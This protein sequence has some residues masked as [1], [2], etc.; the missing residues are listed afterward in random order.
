MI[1]KFREYQSNQ[2]DFNAI[3][4]INESHQYSNQI[5]SVMDKL[6]FYVKRSA[7][8]ENSN[9]NESAKRAYG[10]DIRLSHDERIAAACIFN[11]MLVQFKQN[12][13][14]ELSI[15]E[16]VINQGSLLE[17]GVEY[18]WDS[19]AELIKIDEGLKDKFKSLLKKGEDKVNTIAQ[20]VIDGAKDLTAKGVEVV[21]AKK[22][23]L[24]TWAKD[25]KQEFQDRYE[26]LK[27]LVNDIVKKGIDS[28][29]KFIDKLLKV[30]TSI[31]SNLLEVIKK[32]GGTKMEKEEKA[33]EL[34]DIDTEELYKKIEDPGERSFFNNI[35]LRV[36]A[37]LTK[38]NEN[39]AKLMTEAYVAES[40]VDN[41]FIAWLSGYKSDGTKMSW[42]K[43]ILI[44]LCASIIVWLLPK[45]LVFTGLG[46]ALAAFIAGLV[47]LVWNTIGLLK[48]IYKRNK[49]RKQGEKFFDIKTGIFFCASV[50]SLGFSISTFLKTIGPLMREICN[51]MG[52]T[53]GDDMSKF[54]ELF[55]KFTRKISP[56]ECFKEG[57]VINEI[58][59]LN[60]QGADVRDT[61][62]IKSGDEAV[63][64]LD[65]MEGTTDEQV[66]AFK[67]MLKAAQDAKGTSGVYKALEQFAD[68]KD[69]PWTAVFDSQTYGGPKYIRMAIEELS[70]DMGDGALLGNLGSVS[71]HAATG[72]L[73]G[74]ACFL[75]G[76][77][78]DTCVKILQRASELAGKEFVLQ[79][80]EYG[81]GVI[82]QVR[83][84]TTTV[85][86]AFDA[87]GPNIP[88]LPMVMPFFDKKKWGQYKI[89]FASG[90][91][92]SAGY[93]V[94]KV[95][96]MKGDDIKPER[97]CKALDSLKKLH[98]KAWAD[99]QALPKEEG[100]VSEKKQEEK[101]DKVEEPQYIVFFVKPNEST[102]KTVDARNKKEEKKDSAF[103]IVIDTLTM[104][105]ADIC[106]FE[107]SMKIRRR[108]K[109]YY[110]K[111]LFSRL[112]FRPLENN[113]NDTKD[114]I[115]KTL[116]QTM[117]TLITQNVMFG[118]GKKYI[119]SK[120]DGDKEAEFKQRTTTLDTNKSINWDKEKFELGNFK[121]QELFDCVT[122]S[123]SNNKRAYGFL[124]GEYGSKVTIREGKD[125]TLKVSAIRDTSTIENVRYYR[126]SKDDYE[127]AMKKYK[128]TAKTYVD[129]KGKSK[130]GSDMK[131]PKKPTFIKGNDGEYYKRASAKIIKDGTTKTFDF[132]DIKIIPLLKK[133]DL[134]DEII[135]NKKFK[136]LLFKEENG[137]NPELNSAAI[138]ILKPF[139]YRPESS[140]ARDDE[141][142]LNKALADKDIH[143][144]KIGW[145]K[146][147]FKDEEQLHDTFKELIEKIWDYLSEERRVMF[148]TVDFNPNRKD[149]VKEDYEVYNT[150]LDELIEECLNEDYEEDNEYAYDLYIHNLRESRVL[151]YDD[152]LMENYK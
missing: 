95:E 12:M 64:V 27:T 149:D 118:M 24:V 31:G 150:V 11:E 39:A 75:T 13:D 124:S 141:N 4:Q 137:K 34:K 109:P 111:G 54:G 144:E 120:K 44:G 113:D 51:T 110:M 10:K 93:V 100:E 101:S 22:D 71:T 140:F 47:G 112:S 45:V 55:Y 2:I 87:V 132:A 14:E 3:G 38:D 69:L 41:K 103:G 33:A 72:G 67:D 74:S 9:L 62:L 126:I 17:E 70:K 105:C 107:G 104:M 92:G 29:S 8:L 48:L 90:T 134:H 88:F 37:I 138:E 42:W 26:A 128:D 7:A 52:W 142:E 94:D 85:K 115:R 56:K 77:P 28:I 66:N 76:V 60:N 81:T 30:F 23:D 108:D 139:L 151:T 116:G 15:Y 133:G 40:I 152:F 46:T 147:L 18:E 50:I 43:C 98:D 20:K 145:I 35:V 99:F 102:G 68:N 123:S 79:M 80:H 57:G 25:A 84:V 53:G 63:K 114:Y 82:A 91:R 121:P 49:E 130:D 131:K 36:E 146:N 16:A 106:D 5:C 73:Y 61:D 59:E 136:N 135:K 89:R 97:E 148:K 117:Q 86:G 6:T 143:A 19:F 32:L 65:K 58:K 78:K 127:K 96:M 122:D 119:D 83:T 125:G 21:K 1:Q 129:S